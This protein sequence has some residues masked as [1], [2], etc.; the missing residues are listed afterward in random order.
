MSIAPHAVIT[1]VADIL[2]VP[3]AAL[4]PHEDLTLR[5]LD[6]ISAMRLAGQWRRAGAAVRFVDLLERPTLSDWIALVGEAP[7]IESAN[8][9]TPQAFSP[10]QP[11]DLA[12]MQHAYWAGRQD[13]RRLGGVAA[14]FY[15]EFDGRDIEPDRLEAAVRALLR[16]HEMLRAT[17]ETDGK[18]RILADSPWP[19]LR[20]HDLRHDPDGPAR[21]RAELSHRQLDVARGE[22]FDVQLSLT[23]AGTTRVHVNL[24]MLAADAQSLRILFA[25]LAALYRDPQVRLPDLGYGYARYLADHARRVSDSAEYDAAR[26]YWRARLAELPGAPDLPKST[27]A[28]DSRVIRKHHWLAPDAR[29]ELERRAR[30]RGLTPAVAV[31]AVFAEVIAAWSSEQ[32]FLLNLPL[33]DREPVHPDVAALVGDFTSSVLVAVDATVPGTFTERARAVQ[34]R[35]RADVAHAA[36]PGV[37]V[38]RD[39]SRHHGETVL[40]PIVYTSALGLGELFDPLVRECFGDPVWI[41]SQGPQVL[42]DAQVTE[43]DGGLLVNWDVR[44]DA[45]PPG[46]LEAMFEAYT[47]LLDRLCATETAWDEPVPALLPA[48]QRAVRA[49]VNATAAPRSGAALHE[50]FFALAEAAPEAPA[51]LWGTDGRLSY[52][53]LARRARELAA[54]LPAGQ[55]IPVHLPKGPEQIVRVL[56]ILAAGSAYLPVGIDQPPH[57]RDRILANAGPLPEADRD[58]AY[59]LFTSGS[60]GEPKGVQIPHSAAVNTIDDLT[61]RFE[62]SSGDRT[63]AVSA[64]DFDL[65]V[66]DIFAPL[67]TGGA[68]VLMG[69]HERRDPAVWADLMVTHHA[70]V[71]NCVPAV[72]DLLLT[73]RTPRAELPLRVV[74]VGGDR[75]G[76]D[77]PGRLRDVAADCVFA[78]LGGTT[79]TAI[80]STIQL[81]DSVAPHWR[82]VPYGVPLDNVR[83]RV[84]DALDRDRPDWVPGELHIGGAGVARGYLGDPD[85]TRA[86]FD[87][88]WYRTGDLARYWPDGTVEFLGRTDHQVKIRGHRVDL[89]EIESALTAHPAVSSAVAVVI[90]NRTA[91]AVTAASGAD[92][93]TTEVTAFVKDLLP[94][95]ML[96]SHIR[97]LERLPLSPNGKIDRAA[98]RQSLAEPRAAETVSTP[99]ATL[100]ECQVAAVWS[101]LLGV[102]EIGREHDFFVLGGDSMLATRMIGRFP[103]TTL[104]DLYDHRTLAEFASALPA[105]SVPAARIGASDTEI[106]ADPGS[107]F[108]PFPLSDVQRAYWIGRDAGLTLGGVDAHFYTEFDGA[109]VDATRLEAAWNRLI[110][111]HPMLRAVIDADGRQ[112]VRSEVPWCRIPVA[113]AP[114]E[115]RGALADLRARMSHQV[116]DPRHWPLCDVRAVRYRLDGRPRMRI[117]VSM[118]NLVLDGLSI[119]IVLA[120]LDRLYRDP[121]VELPPVTLAFRDYVQQVAPEPDAVD[122]ARAYW[123]DRLV[124]L[125]PAPALPLAVDPATLRAPRFERRVRRIDAGQWRAIGAAARAH[126]V[127]AAT[128]LL[129]CY[130]EVLGVWSGQRDLTVNLT[131]FDR[132]EVHPDINR[133]VGDF[134]SLLLVA[135]RRNADEPFVAGVRRVQ[136]QLG[137]DLSHREVSAVWVLR[138][139]ARSSGANETAMPVVFTSVL[140]L[141]E[142]SGLVQSTAYGERVWGVMQTPQTWLDCKVYESDGGLVVEWDAVTELF[143][144]GVLDAMFEAYLFL[145]GRLADGDWS[146]PVPDLIPDTQR[147]VRQQINDTGQ[148]AAPATLHAAFFATAR[149]EPDRTAL[150]WDG[151]RYSY[152]ELADRALRVAAG[153]V[154]TGTRPGDLVAVSMPR[155]PEQIAAVLGVLAAGAAYVPIGLDQPAAR[156]DR[157]LRAVDP[158]AVLV[159]LADTTQVEP[160][161]APVDVGAD[162]LGYVIFTSGST[163]EPKG[164]CMTHAAAMN[165]VSDINARYQVTGRDRVLAVSALDFDL[166]VYDIFGLLSVGGALVLVADEQRRDAAAWI[167]SARRFG[168]TIWNTVPTLLDM[169]LV[170]AEHDGFPAS[171]RLALVSGD[172]V[173]VDLPARVA[174]HSDGGCRTVA[175]GG[176]TEA[177]IWS[178]AFPADTAGELEGW[179]SIP[180]GFPLRGQHFRVVDPLGADCPEWVAGELWIG[181]AGIARGYHADAETTARAFPLVDGQRWYRTGDFGRYRPGGVLE[182]LGRRDSQVKVRGHR[183][184]LGEIETALRTHP[185]VDR[186]VVVAPGERNRRRLV[187]FVVADALEPDEITDYLS[188]SL[189]PYAVPTTVV[190]VGALPLTA[191]GKVD[192]RALEAQAAAAEVETGSEPPRGLIEST[193]AESWSDLLGVAAVGRHDNFFTLGGDSLLATRLIPRLRA[194][195]L[196]GVELANLFAARDLATFAAGLRTGQAITSKPIIPAPAARHE[197]FELTDVQQAYLIGRTRGLVLGGVGSHYYLEYDD[198]DVDLERLGRAWNRLIARHEMLRAVIDTDGMQRILPDVPP[199]SI[200]VVEAHGDPETAL[201]ALRAELSHQVLDPTRWPVLDVRAVRYDSET[202]PRARVGVSLDNLV[203]DGISMMILLTEL[204]RLYHEPDVELP[205]LDLSFR[206]YLL[207]RAPDPE[208]LAA[209]EDYWRVRVREL[210][211]PPTLPLVTEPTAMSVPRFV[212]RHTVIATEVWAELERVARA[213]GLTPSVPLL[214]A[215]AEVLGRW[216]G[217]R[218]LS[219]TVTL[220]DRQDV[221]PDVHRVIGDFTSVLP[222]GYA[223]IAGE[224]WL[225]SVRRLQVQLG[226]DLD[227]AQVSGI[228]AARELAQQTGGSGTASPVVFTSMVG[229]GGGVSQALRWPTWGISQTPQVWLDNQVVECADGLH[230]A[231]DAVADLVEP[232]VLDDMF[233][234]YRELLCGLATTG[235]ADAVTPGLPARQREVRDAV[236]ATGSAPDGE[237]LLH[238]PF[239]ALAATR[240]DRPAVCWGEDLRLSYGEL[241][242]A[243]LRVASWLRDAGV[244]PGDLVVVTMPRGPEQVIAVLGVLAAGAVYVPV[245]TDQPVSR[246][247]RIRDAAGIRYVITDLAAATHA[248]PLDEPLAVHCDGPAYVIFTSGTTGAPKGVEISHRAASNTVGDVSARIGL[249]SGD[250]VLAVSALDFDLSVYDLFGPLSVGGAV[251]LLDDGARRDP[252]AWLNSIRLHGVSVWNSVPMLLEM[253]LAGAEPEQ[254]PDRLRV[255]LVSGDRVDIDLPDRLAR[256]SDGRCRLLAL[257]GATEAAIWSTALE[258]TPVDPR[259]TTIPYGPPLRGQY[260]RVVDEWEAD[261]PDWVAGELW[262]GGAGLATGYRA[263]AART[264]ERFVVRAG[265]RWYRT[266]DRARYLPGGN[267]ELLGRLD[268]Q[269]KVRGHRVELGEVEAALRSHPDV[270]AAVVVAI[271]GLALHA[272]VVPG[273]ELFA[274]QDVLDHVAGLVPGYAVPVRVTVVDAFPLTA[275][276]KLDRNALRER[277]PARPAGAGEPPAGEVETT[278]ARLCA[279]LLGTA[280]IGR[281]DNFF[282]AGGNSLLATRLAQRVQ[283]SFGVELSLREFF[284]TPTV[285][286]LGRVIERHRST[287]ISEEGV[288]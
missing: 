283:R 144:P 152:G 119:M 6:S 28:V 154:R 131:V 230:V 265:T 192:R 253:L 204:D 278:L 18:Q 234:A 271:D 48:A 182:F 236:N 247:R 69:E 180:Y 196:A 240:P 206:D 143:P 46:A 279:E 71:L 137:R 56:G 133:V 70:T 235:L 35:F 62:I 7:A 228:W 161:A 38:L 55:L 189:P 102:V 225:D 205:Q 188:T 128:T 216:S 164:V 218:D 41:V 11:F 136:D 68:V 104:A 12:T 272:W 256:A 257:G 267:I 61:A 208:A 201:T 184:D 109:D 42:L 224:P 64:L 258:P 86:K 27:V 63:L 54:T 108:E 124:D 49:E 25:D 98:L 198:P 30:G 261:C 270:A 142:E 221:H 251:V 10:E 242:D 227:H 173:G 156:R 222:V 157:I 233:A 195:G 231:W 207:Q 211:P 239:F 237:I 121:E 15:N 94:E 127:T 74:L 151:G 84:V 129:T 89:G 32:K 187:G 76:P 232:A 259:W 263:D 58:L 274:E 163:G 16:R 26:S 213:A 250:R 158:R 210:P 191:N 217:R 99:P 134:T 150:L 245:G 57:R 145:I 34:A 209:A 138:E 78:A 110:A 122:R 44:R 65:S 281:H 160:L 37:E 125:P 33:F 285:A 287:Q 193:V 52:G 197:P 126:G 248:V 269:V 229:V 101:Q 288:I 80:H 153:L 266:G 120:E 113:E 116:R 130:A 95:A 159:D 280:D 29:R 135:C 22:V 5:G 67:S 39:L 79:E 177:G 117:G 36:Y 14:Q 172:W 90:G 179:T 112:R 277:A 66:F 284:T 97:V 203:L 100:V 260:F 47:R 166:S 19:G 148:P 21:L 8:N 59:V 83:C 1:C 190:I 212:R 226:R 3:A 123:Q 273:A 45:L 85:R 114:T 115:Y 183:I 81:V 264:A 93:D 75:V 31:A 170:A 176:A 140:G 199:L 118:N 202:G 185:R 200:R 171:L 2:G 286:A 103:G 146:A 23:P 17:F 88:D 282:T 72:L 178:N 268:D 215:Y 60:T 87:S 186:A 155:G 165:T 254:L 246:R 149:R 175:L 243:A 82:S 92:V 275:N 40:A 255:A 252:A 141:P 50:R 4:D 168:V 13:T 24:D 77:L 262:I 174:R 220:F 244:V 51:V 53:E 167:R 223:P 214:A 181:G 219:V 111:R 238:A 20:V 105:S 139:L 107:W 96:P 169:L 91:A 43:F 9:G 106:V 249:G 241:A 162:E 73:D 194:A 276:G 147:A 132:Q